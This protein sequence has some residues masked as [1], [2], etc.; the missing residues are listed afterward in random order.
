M[1]KHD[2]RFH[3]LGCPRADS[4]DDQQRPNSSKDKAHPE[5]KS[6]ARGINTTS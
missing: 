6:K 1:R 4:W 5:H 2:G 3:L